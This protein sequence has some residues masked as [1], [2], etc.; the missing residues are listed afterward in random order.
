MNKQ[1]WFDAREISPEDQKILPILSNSA[2]DYLVVKHENRN[3]YKLPLKTNFVVWIDDETSLKEIHKEDIIM[4]SSEAILIKAKETKN[5]TCIYFSVDDKESLEKTY[6]IGKQ[7]D[8]VVI[9][10]QA[11]TNI[12]LE[13]VIAKLQTE[14]TIL[15][16]IVKSAIAAEIAL[17][18]MEKG[19]DGV[20]LK[21]SDIA[22][23]L[24]TK[25]LQEKLLLGKYNLVP[26]VVKEIEHIGMG[27]RACIDTT[28][29][30]NE[31]EGMLIGSTSRGGILV[32][33]E[34]HYLPYMNLRPFR[35]NAGAVHSYVWAAN[36]MTEY[37][38]DLKAGSK[39]LVVDNTGN[40]REVS[41]GRVKIEVRPLLKII[42]EAEGVE[43]NTIVQDDWHIRIL[44]LNG[45]VY[46][47]SC[48]KNGD[49]VAAY[50]CESGRH[51]GIKIGESIL[52]K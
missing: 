5:K 28:S 43:I 7:Y 27:Y 41:V 51:V 6:E 9:E 42:V 47:A 2:I 39:V 40:T 1:L 14:K 35:V 8:Y 18:V 48:L 12:P 10:F 24:K 31:N 45:E 33:S 30:L 37:L 15:L 19:S 49:V 46:N 32:S 50:I 38:T 44:G 11:E 36:D 20:L 26:G 22:E 13:L 23:I 29:I 21:T 52:E 34:T 4:S 25:A 16:K 17:G 3:E